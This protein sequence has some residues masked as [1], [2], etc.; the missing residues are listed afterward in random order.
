MLKTTLTGNIGQDAEVKA[1]EN[2]RSVIT[3]SVAH[4]EKWTDKNGVAQTKTEWVRCNF[5]KP[6]DKTSV[7]MYL[8]K[9]VKVLVEGKPTASAYNNQQGE[10]IAS[11]EINI[12]YLELLSSAQVDAQPSQ[13]PAPVNNPAPQPVI[14][15]QTTNLTQQIAERQV[16]ANPQPQAQPQPVNPAVA[17][18][19]PIAQPHVQDVNNPD[20]DLPF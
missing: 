14:P 2:G 15:P 10:L 7:A 20:D 12:S 4:S 16:A 18:Q 3:F 9:G 13:N 8:K 6:S 17:Y 5:W 19:Q 1:F 11:I